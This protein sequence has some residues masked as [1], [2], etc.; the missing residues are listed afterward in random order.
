MR[1]TISDAKQIF[2]SI[3]RAR[4]L[5]E[6]VE[7]QVGDFSWR[8]DARSDANEIVI[9]FNGLLGYP[10]TFTQRIAL[11]ITTRKIHT[12]SFRERLSSTTVLIIRMRIASSSVS[13]PPSSF[14][15]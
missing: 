9:V 10:N 15:L 7:I 3:K 2:G 14:R 6:I 8:T 5:Q 12:H 11:A 13:S 1:F 4:D